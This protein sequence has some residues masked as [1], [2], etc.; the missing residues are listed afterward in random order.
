MLGVEAVAERMADHLIGHHPTMPGA[1]EMAQAVVATGRLKDSLHA[2]MM[3][4]VP[5]SMQDDF[6]CP[7]QWCYL[8]GRQ[9]SIL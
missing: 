5:Y 2:S 9:D 7:F 8:W 3:T 6:T 4:I 1:G